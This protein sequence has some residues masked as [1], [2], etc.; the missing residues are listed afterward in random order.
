MEPTGHR[1]AI[2]GRS[3]AL[4]QVVEVA[5]R[6][7]SVFLADSAKAAVV[8]ARQAVEAIAHSGRPTY[9]VNTGLGAL[10]NRAIEASD[11][12]NL[13]HNLLRSHASG[14]GEL[15]PDD[16]ARAT[17]LIRANSLATG[18]FRSPGRSHRADCRFVECGNL[19]GDPMPGITR[20]ERRSRARLL[21]L[22]S[23]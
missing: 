12:R 11:L 4:T 14:S 7:A 13:Q 20:R 3:L 19:A 15:L 23:C 2:D 5:R 16:V 9:G 10:S 21:I 18:P 22:V 6:G 17:M 1:I 8:A